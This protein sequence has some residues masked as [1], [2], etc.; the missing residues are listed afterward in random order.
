MLNLAVIGSRDFYDYS[1]VTHYLNL[2]NI[3]HKGDFKIISGGA[4]GADS[5]AIKYAK[6][7][8]VPYKE[9]IPDWSIGKHAGFLR[10]KLIID[11]CD[12]V[13]AFW[14][15]R[16]KGTA[17]SMSLAEKQNKPIKVVR[18]GSESSIRAEQNRE[19]V[20]GI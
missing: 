1:L 16:S 12:A 2:I 11:D 20:K 19:Q 8:S 18:Y 13:L 9:Y 7:Y 14:D 5:L 10:N 4:R 17:H 3:K 15:G 6:A